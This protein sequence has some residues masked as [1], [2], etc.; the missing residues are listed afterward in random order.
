MTPEQHIIY[1]Y[2]GL[3]VLLTIFFIIYM[4]LKDVINFKFKAFIK[5]DGVG[6]MYIDKIGNIFMRYIGREKGGEIR[7][8][9]YDYIIDPATR[10]FKFLGIP[11]AVFIEGIPKN[12]DILKGE[13][14]YTD[15]RCA[16]IDTHLRNMTDNSYMD[17]FKKYG[18]AVLIGLVVLI[19]VLVANSFFGYKV[20]EAVRD[21]G[22]Q[23]ISQILSAKWLKKI[24]IGLN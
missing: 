8:K 18:N 5:K 21:T 12:V 2:S 10:T 9:G 3:V 24:M 13:D 16:D 23:A 7:I 22:G 11:T 19:L 4:W 14:T 1:L 15:I 6:R 20:Y 17:W